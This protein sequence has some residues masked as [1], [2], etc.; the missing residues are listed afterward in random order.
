[1]EK[2]HYLILVLVGVAVIIIVTV[3]GYF[4][5]R[6]DESSLFDDAENPLILEEPRGAE[7]TP[8]NDIE[9]PEPT[10]LPTIPPD[11]LPL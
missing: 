10:I 8:I 1:M 7:E 9:L 2:Q 3:G 11:E 4:L 6:D 5:G